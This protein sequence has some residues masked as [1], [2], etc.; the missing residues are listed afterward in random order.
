MVL[1]ALCAQASAIPGKEYLQPTDKKIVDYTLTQVQKDFLKAVMDD[2]RKMGKGEVAV[3]LNKY[4]GEERVAFVEGSD[5]AVEGGMLIPTDSNILTFSKKDVD[6]WILYK[7]QAVKFRDRGNLKK[8]EKWK[9]DEQV[10]IRGA[11]YTMIHEEVHMGQHNPKWSPGDED[12]AYYA[13]INE[14]R[15]TIKEDMQKIQEILDKK[16][17]LPGDQYRLNELLQDL[18]ISRRAYM[19]MIGSFQQV[20]DESKEAWLYPKVTPEN[21]E[22]AISDMNTLEKEAQDLINR[23]SLGK[24]SPSVG[25]VGRII[26]TKG[27]FISSG[28]IVGGTDHLGFANCLCKC[29]CS[30]AR[31][32]LRQRRRLWVYRQPTGGLH[33]CRIWRGTCIYSRLRGML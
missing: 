29:G 22:N 2:L 1:I 9:D 7:E 13:A 4:M 8:E 18:K 3:S 19:V 20:I 15:G 28:N 31:L 17:R 10:L 23:A 24:E 32:G 21:F 5:A 14:A 33:L 27:A 16:E 26:S 11:A 25:S 30:Q 6:N 12:P